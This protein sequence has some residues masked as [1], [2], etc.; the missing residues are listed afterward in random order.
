MNQ[1][2]YMHTDIP[3]YDSIPNLMHGSVY[4]MIMWTAYYGWIFWIKPFSK[5]SFC[6]IMSWGICKYLS[7]FRSIPRACKQHIQKTESIKHFCNTQ[8]Y[9]H[10]HLQWH[11]SERCLLL[12]FSPSLHPIFSKKFKSFLSTELFQ[13][14]SLPPFPA[15]LHLKPLCGPRYR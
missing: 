10:W 15:H 12:G 9:Y 7:G 1:C 14:D 6:Q 4:V 13:S 3:L 5:N 2:A 8:L 11:W